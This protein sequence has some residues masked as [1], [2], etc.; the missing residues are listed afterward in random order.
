[1]ERSMKRKPEV[2]LTSMNHFEKDC[3]YG[4]GHRGPCNPWPKKRKDFLT[5]L[6]REMNVAR[7]VRDELY[8]IVACSS[9]SGDAELGQVRYYQE[10][11]DNTERQHLDDADVKAIRYLL[12][13]IASWTSSRWDQHLRYEFGDEEGGS[14][15]AHIKRL[16]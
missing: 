13:R 15:I 5:E 1:M 9:P 11:L 6:G 14:M 2:V 7:R 10:I 4:E 12:V 8:C 16:I 3:R